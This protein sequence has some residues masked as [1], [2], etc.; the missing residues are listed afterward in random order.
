MLLRGCAAAL[1]HAITR[2][3]QVLCVCVF[4]GKKAAL[5]VH[6]K[7]EL[8]LIRTWRA[9]VQLGWVRRLSRTLTM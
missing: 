1:A 6:D 5:L 8:Q 9:V 4:G 2:P 3:V 7:V